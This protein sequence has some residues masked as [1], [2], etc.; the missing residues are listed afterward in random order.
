MEVFTSTYKKMDQTQW[1]YNRNGEVL[2]QHEIVHASGLVY[3]FPLQMFVHLEERGH[4]IPNSYRDGKVGFYKVAFSRKT[5]LEDIE[6][7]Y[8]ISPGELTFSLLTLS[9]RGVTRP[10]DL[11]LDDAVIGELIKHRFIRVDRS[12]D[13]LQLGLR[14]IERVSATY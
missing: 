12:R 8:G 7:K 14:G 11:G 5:T 9:R 1:F 3:A 13:T 10:K 4:L 2:P 6:D